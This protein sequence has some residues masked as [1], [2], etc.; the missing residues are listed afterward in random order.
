MAFNDQAS[1]SVEA[2]AQ[3]NIF[4]AFGAVLGYIGAEAAT[5][6]SFE[7][8]LWPQRFYSSF[9]LSMV[10]KLALL[11]PMGGPLHKAALNVLDV[12]FEHGL[13]KGP[14]QG[15]M[16]GTVFFRHQDW[17]YTMHGDGQRSESHTEPLRNCIWTTALSHLPIPLLDT[18]SRF[19]SEK[20]AEKA[21][22]KP[23][24]NRARFAVN[25]LTI[26]KATPQDKA[27]KIAFVSEG[28]STPSYC[29]I[30]ALFST[31]LTG[32]FAAIGVSLVFRSPWAVLWVIPLFL[33]LVS[34]LLA[35]PRQPLI[36][37]GSSTATD[38]PV[39][40]FELH[41]PLSRG[42]FILITGPPTMVLQF[43]RHYGHPIRNRF[44]E[45]AQLTIVVLYASL[46][47]VSLLCS[48]IWM[49]MSIQYAWVCHQIYVVLA[50]HLAR[51]SDGVWAATEA[52]I[53]QELREKSRPDGVRQ[54]LFGHERHGEGTI[55]ISLVVTC[56]NR[57]KEGMDCIKELLCCSNLGCR[58]EAQNNEG[59]KSIERS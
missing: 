44:R 51:Y 36:S 1:N 20:D 42:N 9:T 17:T 34:A 21:D 54:I 6:A 30:L 47:P 26:S 56:K 41:C 16:L 48:V 22:V 37:Q 38:D 31:E 7:H 29:V 27:S 14:Y 40:N 3:T 19:M 18:P 52:R 35:V 43:F 57:Y 10:P 4:G 45:L 33:R 28:V 49:P 53:A 11:T 39:Q 25:H 46:F 50:M 2:S 58:S 59:V 23:E 24:P 12:C 13:F 8:L 15:H 55:K 32:I 5:S